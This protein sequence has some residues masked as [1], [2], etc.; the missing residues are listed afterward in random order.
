MA[1]GEQVKRH[2]LSP[3]LGMCRPFPSHFG[4]E[5]LFC[6]EFLCAGGDKCGLNMSRSMVKY[7]APAACL[8]LLTACRGSRPG[9]LERPY[10]C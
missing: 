2:S 6:V 9:A 7:N 3:K 8:S 5:R 10:L 4:L 1:Q